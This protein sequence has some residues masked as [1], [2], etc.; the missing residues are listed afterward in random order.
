M[1]WRG[2]SRALRLLAG[3]IVIV[4]RLVEQRSSLRANSRAGSILY[5]KVEYGCGDYQNR[6]ERHYPLIEEHS[7]S[8]VMGFFVWAIGWSGVV[9]GQAQPIV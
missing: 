5:R 4:V 2:I 7:Y 3:L 8:G 6:D 9:G 1:L